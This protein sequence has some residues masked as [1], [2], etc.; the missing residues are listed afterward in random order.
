MHRRLVVCSGA[1]VLMVAAAACAQSADSRARSAARRERNEA[2]IRASET[3]QRA[4]T[5]QVP[6]RILYDAPTSLSDSNARRTGAAIVG[7]DKQPQPMEPAVHS[8]SPSEKPR[9]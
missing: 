3:V 9:G 4:A 6:N 1:V 2:S 5:P 7:L 8:A